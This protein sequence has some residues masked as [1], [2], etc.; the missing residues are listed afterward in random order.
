[1]LRLLFLLAATVRGPADVASLASAS[2][3]VVHAQ[4]VLRTSAWGAG[5]GQIFTTV[6]LRS[7]ETW[8][9]AAQRELSVVVPGGAVDELDQIVQGAAAFRDGEEVVVFLERRAPGVFQV[10]RMALGKFSVGAPAGLPKRAVRDRTGLSCVGCGAD[11]Q[12]D[13]SLDELRAHVLGSL[14]K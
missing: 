11:E 10:H 2:D 1:M 7:L 12:D 13:L 3:T 5:G 4:V 14:S 8:K 6:V 9:G